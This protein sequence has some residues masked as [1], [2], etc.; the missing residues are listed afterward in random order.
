[1]NLDFEAK[2]GLAEHN[3]KSRKELKLTRRCW[4]VQELSSV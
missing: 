1:V 4:G 2:R 3:M